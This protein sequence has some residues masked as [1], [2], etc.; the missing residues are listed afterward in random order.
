MKWLSHIALLVLLMAGFAVW[1][2][3]GM[4]VIFTLGYGPRVI[5]ALALSVFWAAYGLIAWA[6]LRRGAPYH[7]PMIALVPA[8]V[9][10]GLAYEGYA[11]SHGSHLP[12]PLVLQ[13]AVYA[14]GAVAGAALSAHNARLRA[15]RG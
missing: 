15:R 8:P 9:L 7:W 5:L 14:A 3:L 6:V 11:R 2:Y 1:E 4:I 12:W 10:I 13:F